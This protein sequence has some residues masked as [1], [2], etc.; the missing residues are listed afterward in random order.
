MGEAS[1]KFIKQRAL[2]K[3]AEEGYEVLTIGAEEIQ[4]LAEEEAEAQF[5]DEQAYEW[6]DPGQESST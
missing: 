4:S 6:L 2:R 5:N 1:P 3:H